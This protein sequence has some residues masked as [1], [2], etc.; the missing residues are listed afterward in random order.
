MTILGH[1]EG[2]YKC[3]D[4]LMSTMNLQVVACGGGLEGL[5]A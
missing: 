1:F 3:S 2:L 4:W 5:R